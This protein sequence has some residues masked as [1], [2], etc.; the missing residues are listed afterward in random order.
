MYST[1]GT[2]FPSTTRTRNHAIRAP[3]IQNHRGDLVPPPRSRGR[4]SVG[5]KHL[6]DSASRVRIPATQDL[7]ERN[8]LTGQSRARQT[9]DNTDIER[10]RGSTIA[11]STPTSP[12][13][14]A[15]KKRRRK[16]I[17]IE[18][19][20][21]GEEEY[22]QSSRPTKR[23]TVG[24]ASLINSGSL[25]SIPSQM[26]APNLPRMEARYGHDP[27]SNPFEGLSSNA[28]AGTSLLVSADNQQHGRAPANVPLDDC[29]TQEQLFETLVIECNLK[30][31]AAAELSAVSATYTWNH[32]QHLIRKG[33]PRDWSIF[34]ED[35]R[36]AWTRE[37]GRFAEDGCEIKMMVH[38]NA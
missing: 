1:P 31:K 24:G 27:Q 32:K 30:G 13:A 2:D 3:Q 15:N 6:S 12:P 28:I 16:T 8:P 7:L 29:G 26:G 11:A 38:V 19:G 10:A 33:R 25:N 14:A 23:T 21:S 5:G 18:P 4:I 22:Q 20:P 17:A 36:K 9:S 34:C 35:I 37:A